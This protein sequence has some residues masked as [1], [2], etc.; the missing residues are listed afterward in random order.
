MKENNKDNNDYQNSKSLIK[1]YCSNT[2]IPNEP[3]NQIHSTVDKIKKKEINLTIVDSL[4][5]MIYFTNYTF[6]FSPC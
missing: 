4:R 6:Y 2:S 3:M 5:Y 1:N